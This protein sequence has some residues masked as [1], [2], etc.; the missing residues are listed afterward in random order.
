MDQI[1]KFLVTLLD[2]PG[3]SGYE[4]PV[5]ELIKKQWEPLTDQIEVSRLGSLHALRQAEGAGSHPSL[6][7]AAHMDAIGFMV[8][9]IRDGFIFITTIGGIDPRILPGQMVTIHGTKEIRGIVQMIPDRLTQNLATGSAPE[10]P[11]LFV[12]TGLSSAEI[13]RT[14]Q[15]GCVI[16]F[17]NAP[18]QFNGAYISGHSL[19]NRASVAALTVCLEEIRNYR[20]SWDVWCAATV[21]EERGLLGAATS[22]FAL[23]PQIA[24]ALDVTFAKEPGLNSHETFPLGKGVTLGIGANIHPALHKEFKRLAD[25]IDLPYSIETMPRGSGTDGMAMQISAAGIPTLVIGIPIRYMHTPVELTSLADIRRAGRLLARFITS[26]NAD[27]LS[28]LFNGGAV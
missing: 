21:Q 26:L 19:D 12:D 16:S 23:E 15:P 18:L 17:A 5:S 8:K 14:I 10:F 1:E 6:M 24:I 25:E 2:A 27:S 3:L 13:K 9:E 20:L 22:A 28:T 4:K 11:R 7:I